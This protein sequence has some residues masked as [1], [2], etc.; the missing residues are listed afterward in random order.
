MTIIPRIAAI[1]GFGLMGLTAPGA[2]AQEFIA[3]GTAGQT[4]VYYVVGQ[5]LCQLVNR[6]SAENGFKCTAP[7]TGGSIANL[8][9]I[10]AGDL[11]F[12][13]VQ[14]DWQLHAA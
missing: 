3:V 2:Q 6:E 1:A 13:I 9:G 11:G 7:A 14:S 8:N 12:G 10:R 4:G 5:S